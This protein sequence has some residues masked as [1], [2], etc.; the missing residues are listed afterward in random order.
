MNKLLERAKELQPELVENRRWLHSHAEV[1]FELTETCA[2]VEE[3]LRE[4]GYEPMILT[5]CFE[6]LC[7]LR[8][9]TGPGQE[10]TCC[11]LPCIS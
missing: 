2:F 1:G 11:R 7:V 3:K 4:L 9:G 5:D 6:T 10:G 8:S